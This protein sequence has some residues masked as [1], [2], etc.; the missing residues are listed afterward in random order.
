ML[1]NGDTIQDL[2]TLT[3]TFFFH[4]KDYQAT[5][6]PKANN[7]INLFQGSYHC[8]PWAIIAYVYR[9]FE[10]SLSPFLAQHNEN[11]FVSIILCKGSGAYHI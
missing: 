7:T 3:T 4:V 1:Q 8:C 6:K 2:T 10:I 5:T 11:N 9:N